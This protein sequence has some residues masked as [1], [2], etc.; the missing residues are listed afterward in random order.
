MSLSLHHGNVLLDI[1][2]CSIRHGLDHQKAL[3]VDSNSHEPLLKAERSTFVT[4][5]LDGKLRGCMGGLRARL[6]LICDVS[7]HAFMAAFKDPR[8]SEVTADELPGLDVHLSIL[9]PQTPIYFESEDDLLTQMRPGIDGL[10]IARDTHRATF[11]PSVW[12]SLPEPASFLRRLKE[13][14]AISPASAPSE[15]WRYTV[16][17]VPR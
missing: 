6:P 4:L 8:F 10:V 3:V 7:E 2:T 17:S 11:L 12:E 16:E 13:K 15:A 9:S 1:A 5:H 14:A